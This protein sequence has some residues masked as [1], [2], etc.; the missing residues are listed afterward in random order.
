ME[1]EQL[2]KLHQFCNTNNYERVCSYILSCAPYSADTE[3]LQNTLKTVYE[4]YKKFQ[5]Y[6]EALRVAQK[7]NSMELITELMTECK[8]KVV[9]KQMAYMLGRQRNPYVSD[10]QDIARIVSNEKLSE[11]FKALARDLDTLTPKHPDAVYKSHLED[12]R[13]NI[14]ANIDSAKKNLAMTYVNAFVNAGYGKDLLLTNTQND[15]DWVFKCKEDGQIAAAASLG[16][17]LLWDIEEGLSQ[18]D[19]Y[20]ERREH[21]IV[22]GSYMGLGLINSGI[23]NECDP[24]QAILIDKLQSC[25]NSTLKIGCLMGLSFTYA[26]S[27]RADLLEAISPVILDSGNSTQL[28]AIAAL[29]IGLIYVGSCDEDAAQNI[30]QTLLEKTEEQLNDPFVKLFALGLGLLFLGQQAKCEAI[31]ECCKIL[32]NQKYADFVGLVVETCAYAGS[33]NVLQI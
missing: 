4:V 7:I 9:L 27:A 19:K 8:D 29:A 1:V 14:G 10:D 5:Q 25:E 20:M 24:V 26:G 33:G 23:T 2:T 31:L 22:A 11:H 32:P 15:E 21:H 17:L 28:Q 13:F 18:I 6:P 12:K 3:E 30:I 16:M